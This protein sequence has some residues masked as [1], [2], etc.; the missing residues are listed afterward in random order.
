MNRKNSVANSSSSSSTPDFRTLFESAPG[1]YL[2][3][4]PDLT[5]VAVSGAYL[6]ATM[7]RRED[8]LGRRLFDVFPDNPDDPAATGVRNLKASLSRVLQNHAADAMAVQKYDIRRPDSGGGGFEERFWSPVNCPVLGAD[9]ALAYIIHRVEDVTEFVRLK[10]H[11]VEQ[12]KLTQE[13]RT[14]AERMEGEIYLRAQEVQEANRRLL[15]A[16]E[17][18]AR[19]EQKLHE[20]DE[21]KS[22]FFANVSHELRT[23]LTLI[24][25]PVERLLSTGDLTAGQR[26]D[27]QV[28]ERNA[29]ALLK[30]VNDL[31]DVSRLDAGKLAVDYVQIDL[32]RLVRQIA[33]LFESHSMERGFAFTV[34]APESAPAQVDP[35]KVQR[36][37]TNLLSNAFKF[38]PAN[39]KVRCALYLEAGRNGASKGGSA[40]LT[41]SDS[42]PGVPAHLRDVVFDR[43]FQ[44][45]GTST[46]RHG[47]TGLGLA[48]A[49]DFVVLHGGMIR[50]DP[51]S[52]G[53]A[54]FTVELPLHAP[55]GASVRTDGWVPEATPEVIPSEPPETFQSEAAPE[56]AHP[57]GAGRPLVLVVE[58]NAEMRR[59]IRE[60]LAAEYATEGAA[61][62]QEGLE[63]ATSLRPDLI[64]SDVMMPRLSGGRMVQE[65]RKQRDLDA[66][67]VVMLTAR[68]EDELRISLLRVGAQDYV[69]KPFAAEELLARVRN[70]VLVKRTRERMEVEIAERRRAEEEIRRRSAQLEAANKELETF[71]YSV[72]HDLRAPLRAIDGFSQALLEES[73]RTLDESARKHLERVRAATQRMGQLIDDLIGLSRL[74]RTEMRRDRVDLSDLARRVADDLRRNQPGRQVTFSIAEGIAAQGDGRL[75][76]IVL[77]NLLGNAWKFTRNRPDARIEFGVRRD[78]GRPVFFVRDNGAG[79]D[80]A[81][82]QKLFGAFQRLHSAQQFE[83]TGIGLATVARIVRRHGGDVRAEGIVDQG[84]TFY[85]TL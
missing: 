56:T 81:Y 43:F 44:V 65:L 3:L 8:I 13:L 14:H 4:T 79:F 59:H 5:I 18:L 69:V 25:G 82:A 22:R 80:M 61:D 34:V 29:R 36:V 30:H 74:T 45:E 17:E 54:C 55:P 21:L 42:G 67:P 31:L 47:G 84:A 60:I 62:G 19:K 27:L 9:G 83:G 1:L 48:I 12:D 40:I 78:N 32:A 24:L 49:K 11:G 72:S 50:V 68:A 2:V 51:A 33:S 26:R 58:D 52:E 76:R 63:K 23:P 10:R 57:E 20:L 41:V 70:L 77:E 71:S 85:F 73:G 35:D 16:N 39:G 75:L 6:Q 15:A 66:I 64:L 37:L 7:T 53:G 46:R 38:T 28:V